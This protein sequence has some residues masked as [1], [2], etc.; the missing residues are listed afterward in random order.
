MNKKLLGVIALVVIAVSAASVV[1]AQ[2]KPEE[3]KSAPAAVK[4][5]SVD[6]NGD[7]K[8]SLDEA[9]ASG[10]RQFVS[11][12]KSKDGKVSLEEFLSH[13]TL[14]G[15]KGKKPSEDQIKQARKMMTNRFAELDSDKNK[16][17]SKA[18]LEADSVARHK[19]M[20]ADQD[21]F[22]SQDEVRA[23]RKKAMEVRAQKL[24]ELTAKAATTEKDK[25]D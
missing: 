14:I 1:E 15:P 7:G 20:D 23:F 17:L 11:F 22:V 16:T 12:D 18:E 10:D 4:G 3:S 25:K 13:M 9:K 8:V 19:A 21:G 5:P 6:S 2:D 24:K